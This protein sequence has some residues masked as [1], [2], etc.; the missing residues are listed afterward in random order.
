[1]MISS[2]AG[3]RLAKAKVVLDEARLLRSR[4]EIS[5][6]Q[7]TEAFND[8]VEASKRVADELVAQGFHDLDGGAS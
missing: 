4:M 5:I 6:C 8:Y 1:M 2:S 3:A 7:Y